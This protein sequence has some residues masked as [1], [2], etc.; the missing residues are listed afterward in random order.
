M[1][2]PDWK[3]SLYFLASVTQEELDAALKLDETCGGTL[4]PTKP[5]NLTKLLWNCCLELTWN[6]GTEKDPNFKVHDGN[7]KPQGFGHIGFL[8]DDLDAVCAKMEADGVVFKKKPQD[9]NMR[10]LAFAYDP[11]GYWIEMIDRKASFAGICA[12][13]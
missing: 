12:N 6:H 9:G 10:G 1:D 13:Y 2:F 4:D 11:N 8:V 5:N 3:F 7:A